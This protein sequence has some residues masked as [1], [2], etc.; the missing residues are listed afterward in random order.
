MHLSVRHFA[1]STVL[2]RSSRLTR[3]LFKGGITD[4]T[5]L[6][7]LV[8]SASADPEREIA[9]VVVNDW[10]AY[11]EVSNATYEHFLALEEG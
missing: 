7:C 6:V 11:N 2:H 10:V 1:G 4:S 5:D 9:A 3:G 8:D